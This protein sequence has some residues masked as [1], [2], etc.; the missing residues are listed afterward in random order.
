M[1]PEGWYPHL[2][3]LVALQEEETAREATAEAAG[4]EPGGASPRAASAGAPPRV[5]WPREN[6]SPSTVWVMAA[7]ADAC[8][9]K[10]FHA[11]PN[12]FGLDETGFPSRILEVWIEWVTFFS[13]I[14]CGICHLGLDFSSWKGLNYGLVFFHR[15]WGRSGCDFLITLCLMW[16]FVILSRLSNCL[17]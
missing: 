12:L 2:V 8:I 9:P 5:S 7:R 10:I 1:R 4:W 15:I 13:Q 6:R 3:G 16:T 17:A 14:P 11:N